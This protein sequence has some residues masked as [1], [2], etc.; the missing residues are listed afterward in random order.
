MSG[1]FASVAE[2]LRIAAAALLAPA[3]AALIGYTA[4]GVGAADQIL[5]FRLRDSVSITDYKGSDG[6]Q[7]VGD[8]V[9][10]DTEAVQAALNTGKPVW[11]P[12][13][14]A[15]Y[16]ITG[17][18]IVK[19]GQI[20][21]GPG[22]FNADTGWRGLR[23]AMAAPMFLLGDGV[24]ISLRH[25]SFQNMTAR[26]DAGPVIQSRYATNWGGFNCAFKSSGAGVNTV[27]C[28]QTYRVAFYNCDIGKSGAG[29]A[30]S[31]LDN[32]NVILFSNCTMSGGTA[33]G[34][35]DIGRSYNVTFDTCVFEVSKYGIQVGTNPSA[36]KGGECNGINIK[37]NSWE[38]YTLALQIG[39]YY[40]CHGV[41]VEGN[42]FSNTG[43]SGGLAKDTTCIIG[44]VSGFQIKGN[45][46]TPAATECIFD[47]WH[48]SDLGSGTM[49][50][51][52][53][54][55]EDN[56]YTSNG[57]GYKFSGYYVTY[58]S[59]LPRIPRGMYFEFGKV[60]TLTD[61]TIIGERIH[62]TTG[63]ITPSQLANTTFVCKTGECG[64]Y[65]EKVELIRVDPSANL[66]GTLNIGYGASAG[67]NIAVVLP[68]GV[69]WTNTGY[70][71]IADITSM[72]T[73]KTTP[74]NDAMLLRLVTAAGT[75]TLQVNIT[76]HK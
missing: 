62:Y 34:V 56:T 9:H 64:A 32:S 10:D 60:D 22:K 44:R 59:L 15:D 49:S 35:S 31:L 66:S 65:I 52:E 51:H 50:V 5:Q 7:P 76:Y 37:G 73:S 8:Y 53:G 24:A 21:H 63:A 33:G 55:I 3:G 67:A 75:G 30:A 74:V 2:R 17:S 13:P 61:A 58:P 26:N 69:S 36:T 29:W 14:V 28:E 42:F 19:P 40:A 1:I 25:M 57:T 38:Q 46:F 4:G 70:G 71:Y 72:L 18:L 41:V 68:G 20:L 23:A 43:T 47:F 54:T 27:D 45:V 12:K 39:N 16:K 48:P 6:L 11:F